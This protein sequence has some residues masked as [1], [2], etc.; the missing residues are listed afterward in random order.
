V[1]TASAGK[2]PDDDAHRG[3]ELLTP[4]NLLI[5]GIA[6]FSTQSAVPAV[7]P[8]IPAGSISSLLAFLAAIALL[9]RIVTRT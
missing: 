2:S 9:D 1:S 4:R 6:G 5:L 8:A 3:R 7:V